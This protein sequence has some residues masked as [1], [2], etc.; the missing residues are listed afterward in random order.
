MTKTHNS[1]KIIVNFFLHLT[2]ALVVVFILHTLIL[3]YF[4]KPV[5]AN[6][7]ILAYFLNFIVAITIFLTLYFLRNR[8]KDQ[9]GFLFLAG[10]F[11]KFLV[12]FIF[13][14]P[15]YINDGSTSKLEFFAFFTPYVISLIT[16]TLALIKLLNLPKNIK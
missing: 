15:S 13:F 14:Y 16:E 3:S 9:L 2:I 1:Q 5:F 10:S 4:E 12:F 6:K 11:L 8:F 7:I